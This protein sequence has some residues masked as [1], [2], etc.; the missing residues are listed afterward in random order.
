M[1]SS[2]IAKRLS[3]SSSQAA[4]KSSLII[5]GP[6]ATIVSRT[7]IPDVKVES[8]IQNASEIQKNFKDRQIDDQELLGVTFD[9]LLKRYSIF[10]SESNH[11]EEIDKERQHNLA[12]MDESK[13]TEFESDIKNNLQTIKERFKKA[14]KYHWKV[15]EDFMVPFLK[16]PNVLDG[17]TPKNTLTILHD[18]KEGNETLSKIKSH[19]DSPEL[20][21]DIH[22]NNAFLKGKWALKEIELLR[23]AQLFLQEGYFCD[24]ISP[25]DIVR[26]TVMEGC[27]PLSFGNPSKS[28]ALN[29]SSDFGDISSG[30][31]AHL[32]GSASLPALVTYFVKNL[33]TKS[34]VLPINLFSIG[35]QYFPLDETCQRSL[36]KT[37]QSTCAGI[38]SLSKDQ[39]Q[40]EES[41][42]KFQE[43]IQAFYDDLGLRYRLVLTSADKLD[44]AESLRLEVQMW[45]P[46]NQDYIKVG[47][48]SKIGDYI[49]ERLLIKYK[50][51]EEQLKNLQLL[52]GS[53]IDAYKVIGCMLEYDK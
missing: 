51:S 42:D 33:M 49:S 3:S 35:R 5:L 23:K 20:E 50:D 4:L 40:M 28:L 43:K 10:K 27:D 11:L 52:S 19:E 45:S 30:L 26:S 13:G 38:L 31:G 9:D 16:V 6:K 21:F 12:L 44:I 34:N 15:E 2:K 32:V 25:P 24:I 29:K 46:V 22:S 39:D 48:I 17:R 37:Q 36:F 7:I 41:F 47:H 18:S 8:R 14:Q 53:L 1:I